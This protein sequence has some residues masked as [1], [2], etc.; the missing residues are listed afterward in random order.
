MASHLPRIS[1]HP[2]HPPVLDRLS[3]PPVHPRLRLEPLDDLLRMHALKR[4]RRRRRIRPFERRRRNLGREPMPMSTMRQE[5]RLA[6]KRLST[7]RL[8]QRHPL[9]F[10][11]DAPP[12]VD[13]RRERDF[14]DLNA[15][16]AERDELEK[17]GR[18]G[19]RLGAC[20]LGDA[21]AGVDAGGGR[22][23][24]EAVDG[25]GLLDDCGERGG[26]DVCVFSPREYVD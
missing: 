16:F 24:Y 10:T 3:Q 2:K 20:G 18:V 14:L 22:G 1:P 5:T 9:A 7:A 25:R 12:A 15:V 13:E 26:D 4:T 6:D 19:L 8:R 17:G 11:L 23:P 21:Y